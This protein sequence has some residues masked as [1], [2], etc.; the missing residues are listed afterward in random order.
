MSRKND[1]EQL[2]E[3]LTH[4]TYG[5]QGSE[6]EKHVFREALHALVRLAKAEQMLEL[7]K[8]VRKAAVL[9]HKNRLIEQWKMD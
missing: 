8:D 7:K 5:S 3:Q 9:A 2:I 1:S 6:R 4:A